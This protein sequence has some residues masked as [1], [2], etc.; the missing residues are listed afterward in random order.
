MTRGKGEGSLYK[1]ADGMWCTSIELPPGLDGKRRRK[2][3]C[4]VSKPAVLA[5]MRRIQ[6]EMVMGDD[7]PAPSTSLAKWARDI[8]RAERVA[9]WRGSS[10]RIRH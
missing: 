10:R 2:V 9:T 4:R 3:V 6:A 1:R 5:E 7:L 8:F